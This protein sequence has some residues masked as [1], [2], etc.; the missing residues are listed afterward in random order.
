MNI[1]KFTIQTLIAFVCFNFT[2]REITGKASSIWPSELTTILNRS[3]KMNQVLLLYSD[4]S[5]N[6]LIHQMVQNI[7]RK[8]PTRLID[9]KNFTNGNSHSLKL[10]SILLE[11]TIVVI[12]PSRNKDRNITEV[13][14]ILDS[15]AKI[16]EPLSIP[17]LLIAFQVTTTNNYRDFFKLLWPKQFLDVTVLEIQQRKENEIISK[18]SDVQ[19]VK[20][21]YYNPFTKK[22]TKTS[23]SENSILFP[24]KLRNLNGYKINVGMFHYPP[25]IYIKRNSTK[26]VVSIKGPEVSLAIGL[27]DVLNFTLQ[28]IIYND[29]NWIAG[30]CDKEKNVGYW[31]NVIYNEIQVML[32]QTAIFGTCLN[33]FALI[34]RGTRSF[35]FMYV[36]PILPSEAVL[37]LTERNLHEMLIVFCILFIPWMIAKF[38]KFD[39]HYWKFMYTLQIAFGF[40]SPRDPKENKERLVFLSILIFYFLESS[41]LYTVISNFQI[42]KEYSKKIETFDDVLA[43]NI[44]V[45]G[46]QNVNW[47]KVNE[48]EDSY[49]KLMKKLKG[50]D[51]SFEDCT[52]SLMINKN[53]ACHGREDA[54]QIRLEEQRKANNSEGMKILKDIQGVYASGMYL[55]GGSPLKS[56]IEEIT[57]SLMEAGISNKWD[58]AFSRKNS[59]RK[60]QIDLFKQDRSL[61]FK[62]L[63]VMIM[64]L[65]FGYSL[66]LIVFASEMVFYRCLNN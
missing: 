19:I 28:K 4:N 10:T 40:S 7:P 3:T 37:L 30:R 45:V 65:L 1:M 60:N 43:A 61:I 2:T 38:L 33:N 42:Q 27:S 31:K 46:T 55:S 63:N 49:L 48:P 58:E 50:S 54:A 11:S 23:F 29:T 16:T 14:N 64:L 39:P 52:I 57:L 21:H 66:S 51:E 20:Q 25:Y 24:N 44:T 26:H 15:L 62:S 34:T 12:V 32:P 53:I 18:Y 9:F 17:K 5:N 6:C 36:V 47:H 13:L 59:I 22:C 41:Y 8:I 56:R 35:T